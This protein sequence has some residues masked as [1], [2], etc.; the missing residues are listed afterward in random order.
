MFRL[1]WVKDV[2]FRVRCAE[3]DGGCL[4]DMKDMCPIETIVNRKGVEMRRNA[5]F[6]AQRHSDHI[7][8]ARSGHTTSL[9]PLCRALWLHHCVSCHSAMPS[10]CSTLPTHCAMSHDIA[11]C[12]VMLCPQPTTVSDPLP[13][14]THHLARPAFRLYHAGVLRGV[15]PYTFCCQLPTSSPGH[16][17]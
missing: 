1:E 7:T 17:Q 2:I 15:V 13:P 12:C 5:N 10:G 11:W 8:A 4:L 16:K 3:N 6:Q 14:P 9:P